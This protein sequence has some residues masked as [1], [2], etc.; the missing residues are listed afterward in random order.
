M[1]ISLGEL[2]TQFGC[3]LIG[4]AD[5]LVDNVASLNNANSSS[6]SF[7]ASPAF[8]DQLASTAA[9]AVILCADDAEN[10]PTASLI[11]EN[12]YA[13]FARVSSA[14]VPARSFDPGIHPAAHVSSTATIATSAHV[15]ANAVIDDGTT[16]GEN[17]YIGPGCVIG[18]DCQIGDDCQLI[19]NV[20]VVR[21]VTVGVRCIVHPGVVIGCDGFGNAMTAEGWVKVPQT[22]GVRVGDDVEIGAHSTIDCGALDDTVIEDGVKID[23]LVHIAHNCR[24]GAHTAIA[25]QCGFGGSVVIGQRCMFAGHSGAV[26]HV[27]ICDDVIVS[28]QGMITKDIKEPG[29]YASSFAAE[30]VHDWNRKVARFSRLESL[31][32]RVGKLEKHGK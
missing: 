5:V 28:A 6:L 27:T 4:D 23:N 3:E 31:V 13:C 30:P 24:V 22:G 12:P 25:A 17:T 11:N 21:Q 19:A 10:S 16:I 26:G 20:T 32:E 29:V 9:A 1:A 18:P 14:I 8:K 7:L 15:A 2:A